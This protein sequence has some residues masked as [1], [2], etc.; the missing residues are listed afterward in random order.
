LLRFVALLGLLSASGCA[1]L[2]QIMA[3][4]DVDFALDGVAE[5]RLSGVDL[6]AIRSFGDLSFG[7]G[8]ALASA[9]AGGNLPLAL[10]LSVAASNPPEN[11]DA[12]MVRMDWTLFLDG[13]ET[14]SGLVD[15]EI[16]IP[17]GQRTV[18]PV[19]VSLDLLDFF[20]GSARDLVD[21]ALSLSG[22]GGEPKEVMLTVLPTIETALGPI[23][24]DRP[25]RVVRTTVGR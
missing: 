1:T 2:G 9:I 16:T 13:R 21:L 4:E 20:E 7:D 8:A 19:E 15:R 25:V 23:R 12:R 6:L 11:V 22:Q 3:L 18:F 14:V 10:N 5:A 17:R 24:Y